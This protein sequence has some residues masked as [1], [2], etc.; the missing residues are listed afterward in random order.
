VPVASRSGSTHTRRRPSTGSSARE[1]SLSALPFALLAI[2]DR[3]RGDLE[4]DVRAAVD[5][6]GARVAVLLRDPLAGRADYARCARRLASVCRAAGATFLV[7]AD[8]A[9]ARALAA[10]GVHLRERDATDGAQAARVQLGPHALVGVSRHDLAGLLDSAH[11]SYA[12]VSP[13]FV[14]AGKGP[15]LGVDALRAACAAAPRPVVA[16]GGITP[17]RAADCRAAGAGAVAAVSSVWHGDVGDNVR[18][19]LS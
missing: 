19:L 3:L 5:A 10:D 16:L 14:V 13:V 11:A 9:L 18:R 12:T 1:A 15:P 4:A 6:G 7:H 17:E 2:T 8:A